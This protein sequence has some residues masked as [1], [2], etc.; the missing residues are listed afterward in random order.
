MKYKIIYL[1]S[2][3]LLSSC[4]FRG[5]S[6]STFRCENHFMLGTDYKHAYVEEGDYSTFINTNNSYFDTYYYVNDDG[7][8]CHYH[9]EYKNGEIVDKWGTYSTTN[10]NINVELQDGSKMN[11]EFSLYGSPSID[12]II[13]CT[14]EYEG[15]IYHLIYCGYY[16]FSARG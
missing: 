6:G 7:Y 15:H 10:K 4:T 1:L 8:D 5:Y 2:L 14:T 3:L 16:I 12:F 9:L 13:I 11:F